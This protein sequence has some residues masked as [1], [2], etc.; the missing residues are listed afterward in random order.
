MAT[1]DALVN[2]SI[3]WVYTPCIEL[4]GAGGLPSYER[5]RQTRLRVIKQ[6]KDLGN[7]HKGL[8]KGFLLYVA[9]NKNNLKCYVGKTT[10]LE[11]RKKG[12]KDAAFSPVLS[13]LLFPR[14]IRKHGWDAFEWYVYGTAYS[15]ERLDFAEKEL[16]TAILPE[17]NMTAGGDG[18]LGTPGAWL[19]KTR[20]PES[21]AKMV[22]TRKAR[23]NYVGYWT[24]KKR[25]E[26]TIRKMSEG[27]RG[28]KV[29][30]T[31]KEVARRKKFSAFTVAKNSSPV[32]CL[33]TGEVF[34]QMKIAAR[35][36][37]IEYPS[38]VELVAK[39]KPVKGL[40]FVRV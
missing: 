25:D 22:A 8:T 4:R 24:G 6:I 10:N 28:K 9:I 18:A 35:K 39:E 23:G 7:I 30:L 29:S 26:E 36:Y 40:H 34:P 17:Y 19:G 12:H 33:E 13:L 37:N 5:V 15:K 14:A 16:I 21:I 2:S 3:Q 38:F 11:R 1:S 27:R 31:E 32:R 20:S